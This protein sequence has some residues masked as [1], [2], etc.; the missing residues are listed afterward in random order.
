MRSCVSA[1]L[2]DLDF[3][4]E[5]VQAE[6]R[7]TG[8]I[9]NKTH[10]CTQCANEKELKQ[11]AKCE[12]WKNLDSYPE[13]VQAQVRQTGRSENKKH[14]CTKCEEENSSRSVFDLRLCLATAQQN[15]KNN[16]LYTFWVPKWNIFILLRHSFRISKVGRI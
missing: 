4:P 11:C 15:E 9:R 5:K 14:L 10:L 13:K 12:A 6:V 8:K 3:Y 2:K 1:V 7:K 16:V